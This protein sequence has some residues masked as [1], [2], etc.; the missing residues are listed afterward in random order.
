MIDEQGAFRS[1]QFEYQAH[2]HAIGLPIGR[3]VR[4]LV[5]LLGLSMVA[6]IAGVTETRAVQQWMIDRRPQRPHVLRFALQLASTIA[7]S[8]DAEVIRAWFHS[9][10]PR[11]GDSSPA[12]LLRNHPLGD[13]QGPLVAAMRSF[14]DESRQPSMPGHNT[15]HYPQ[16]SSAGE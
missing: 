10:N 16:P 5:G 9:S 8:H 15:R 6:E 1:A 13:V 2:S 14:L 4:E 3:A 11:L 12:T 7:Q